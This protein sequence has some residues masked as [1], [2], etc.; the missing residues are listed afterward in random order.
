[1][2]SRSICVCKIQQMAVVKR[3]VLRRALKPESDSVCL[4][5]TGSTLQR[6]GATACELLSPHAV[7]ARSTTRKLSELTAA[8]WTGGD[9]LPQQLRDLSTLRAKGIQRAI[10]LEQ[11]FV[12]YVMRCS[13]VNGITFP[14]FSV[15]TRRVQ[16]PGERYRISLQYC[17][18]MSKGACKICNSVQTHVQSLPSSTALLSGIIRYAKLFPHNARKKLSGI[19]LEA[20][21]LWLSPVASFLPQPQSR[22]LKTRQTCSTFL[23]RVFNLFV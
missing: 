14:T 9:T 13:T 7:R 3:W 23:E 21:G 20:A 15:Y 5:L 1:M 22:P 17:N 18:Y 10:Y 8:F 19:R 11:D 12:V 4:T 16:P 6:R 2:I